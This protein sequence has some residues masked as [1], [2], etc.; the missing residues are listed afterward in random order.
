MR[1]VTPE[2]APESL[3]VVVLPINKYRDHT[4]LATIWDNNL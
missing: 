1:H 3:N 4:D 2:A